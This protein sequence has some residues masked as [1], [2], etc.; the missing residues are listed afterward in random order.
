M[1]CEFLQLQ[2]Y[3]LGCKVEKKYCQL[4]PEWVCCK[5]GVTKTTGRQET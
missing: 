1:A 4:H 5:I 2:L 3:T